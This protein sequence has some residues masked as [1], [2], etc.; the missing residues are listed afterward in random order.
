M[1]TNLEEKIISKYVDEFIDNLRMDVTIFDSKRAITQQ[2]ESRIII[3]NKDFLIDN[4][5]EYRV[6]LRNPVEGYFLF[7][8]KLITTRLKS[9]WTSIV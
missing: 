9:N 8:M 3:I 7:Q 2:S 6:L 4:S 5:R 1:L